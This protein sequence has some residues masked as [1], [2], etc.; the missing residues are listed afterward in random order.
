MHYT[1]KSNMP[2][3]FLM[4]KECISHFLTQPLGPKTA[5]IQECIIFLTQY[6]VPK[7]V[8]SLGIC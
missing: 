7:T 6:L 4:H 3:S 8:K 1:H 2:A 5:K